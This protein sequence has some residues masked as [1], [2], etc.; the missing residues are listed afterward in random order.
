MDL[1]I[2]ARY[3]GL[4]VPYMLIKVPNT[5]NKT[6]HDFSQYYDAIIFVL[7][8]V[9]G[10]SSLTGSLREL[11]S[12]GVS[13][14]SGSK[15]RDVRLTKRVALTTVMHCCMCQICLLTR[16]VLMLRVPSAC[17]KLC[18]RFL[19]MNFTENVPWAKEEPVKFCSKSAEIK[20]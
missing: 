10:T 6:V 4:K 5:S 8:L 18:R 7:C 13:D 2:T 12:S 16:T 9:R 3:F 1:Q 11:I 19:K 17:G 15:N 14:P 20:W